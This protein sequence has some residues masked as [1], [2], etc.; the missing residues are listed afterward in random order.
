MA[1]TLRYFDF[2]YEPQNCWTFKDFN[3]LYFGSDYNP[4]G[5]P[6]LT[7]LIYLRIYSCFKCLKSKK[8]CKA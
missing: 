8:L 5:I 4:S 6:R 1:E 7:N 3:E 2:A